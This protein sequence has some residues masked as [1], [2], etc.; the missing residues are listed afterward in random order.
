[1]ALVAVTSP[2]LAQQ[3]PA[4]PPAGT[5]AKNRHAA[6]E[7]VKKAIARSDAGDYVAAIEFYNQAYALVPDAALLPNVGSLYQKLGKP[8]DALRYFCLY[9]SKEPGGDSAPFARTQAKGL[10]LQLGNTRVDDRDVCAP[11]RAAPLPEPHADA[12]IT[13]PVAPAVPAESVAR[14]RSTLEV[15]GLATAAV[16]LLAVGIGTYEG[17]Q[18]QHITDEIN[19]QSTDQPWPD[20]IQDLQHRGQTYEN[21]QIAFLLGGGV[22]V[23]TGAVLF[24]V[25]RARRTPDTAVSLSPTSNGFLVSGKF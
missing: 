21:R 2:A 10:Q 5:S 16:G 11:T 3:H 25:G 23:T 12:P 17:I 15:T 7:L 13:E 19:G 9:L 4:G 6:G 22:L 14:G 8:T 24:F 20:N 18:A 1:M